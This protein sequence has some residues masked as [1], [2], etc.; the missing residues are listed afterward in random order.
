MAGSFYNVSEPVDTSILV[1]W[2]GRRALVRDASGSEIVSEARVFCIAPV[3]TGHVFIDSEGTE[4]PVVSV[5]EHTDLR[6]RLVQREIA[7]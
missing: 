7:L 6:G 4:W 5:S 3:R 2:E 1:R